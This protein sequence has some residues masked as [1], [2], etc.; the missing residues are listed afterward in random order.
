[1]SGGRF[2]HKQIH[3][4]E[5]A[6]KIEQYLNNQGKEDPISTWYYKQWYNEHPEEKYYPIYSKEVNE[7]L[8]KGI[9]ILRMAYVYSQRIDWFL[10][11]D[12]NEKNFLLRLKHDLSE[13]K[14]ARKNNF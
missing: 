4:K 5:I 1:M 10:S 7:E 3:I 6:E 13:I 14:N 9:E 2:N 12:D 8:E 11:G